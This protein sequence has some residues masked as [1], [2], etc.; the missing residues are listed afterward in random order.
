MAL[1]LACV[2]ILAMTAV[3]AYLNITQ[4]YAT[5]WLLAALMVNNAVAAGGEAD[6]LAALGSRPG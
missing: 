5:F 2:A 6:E 3:A 1:S 4:G